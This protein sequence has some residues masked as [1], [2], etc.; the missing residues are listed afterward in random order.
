MY[1]HQIE[2][3]SS[4]VWGNEYKQQQQSSHRSSQLTNAENFSHWPTNRMKIEGITPRKRRRNQ[5]KCSPGRSII[6]GNRHTNNSIQMNRTVC[7]LLST[8]PPAAAHPSEYVNQMTRE[9]C[10]SDMFRSFL[11]KRYIDKLWIV[12]RTFS[13]QFELRLHEKSEFIE[14]DYFLMY[15]T[16]FDRFYSV[17]KSTAALSLAY[18]RNN[19]RRVIA[20]MHDILTINVLVRQQNFIKSTWRDVKTID[21]YE[22]LCYVISDTRD[23]RCN[24]PDSLHFEYL[25]TTLTTITSKYIHCIYENFPGMHYSFLQTKTRECVL[26]VSSQITGNISVN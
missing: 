11:I 17:S 9:I 12:R 1:R 15:H 3:W 14:L 6:G 4:F 16:Q 24:P 21:N 8:P 18:S 2:H 5:K 22:H 23:A 19:N 10:C 20:H 25:I 13:W 26:R 7:R